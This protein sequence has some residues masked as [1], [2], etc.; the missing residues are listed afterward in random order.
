M[1]RFV[2]LLF[3]AVVWVAIPSRAFAQLYADDNDNPAGFVSATTTSTALA[4]GVIVL[5]ISLVVNRNKNVQS[6]LRQN[7]T[8]V[9]V[10]INL[11]AGEAVADLAFLLQFDDRKEFARLLRLHRRELLELSDPD[12]L[13][14]DRAV[15]FIDV[16]FEARRKS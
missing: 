8:A 5:T 11:G 3:V 1:N 16:L 6:Y 10:A 12:K 2:G 7:Q 15:R 4:A 14:A 13:D 9:K